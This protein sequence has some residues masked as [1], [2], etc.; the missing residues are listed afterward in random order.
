M[1]DAVSAQSESDQWR[2]DGGQFIPNPATWLNQ[3]RW[4]DDP[5]DAKPDLLKYTGLSEAANRA[6][7]ED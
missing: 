3:S 4:E 1:L 5:G 7:E 2:K 6:L